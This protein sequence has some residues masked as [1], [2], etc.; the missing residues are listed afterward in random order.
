MPSLLEQIKS[1]EQKSS[2]K[3]Y[4]AE[5][6]EVAKAWIN[7]EITVAQI[8]KGMDKSAGT[9][10]SFILYAVKQGVVSGKLILK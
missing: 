4:N 6:I 5:E 10:H 7:G 9:V 8:T 1:V 3:E 2:K